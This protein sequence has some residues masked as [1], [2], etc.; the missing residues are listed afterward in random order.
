MEDDLKNFK[1]E[2]DLKNF[3]MEDDL[4]N[5]KMEDDLKNFKTTSKISKWKMTSKISGVGVRR[6][7]LQV[8]HSD[9]LY[10]KFVLR[11]EQSQSLRKK[12]QSQHTGSKSKLEFH[13]GDPSLV[14]RQITF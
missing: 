7:H 14:F 8:S 3:K 12:S 4:K 9:F 5:F 10:N 1:M 2:D 13:T 6:H 11:E